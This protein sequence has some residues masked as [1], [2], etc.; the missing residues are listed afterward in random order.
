MKKKVLKAP[1]A[2]GQLTRVNLVREAKTFLQK[3]VD[4]GYDEDEILVTI[5]QMIS[6]LTK[7]AP[8]QITESELPEF[9]REFVERLLGSGISEN[10]IMDALNQVAILLIRSRRKAHEH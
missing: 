8:Q 2:D 3:L 5:K 7:D 10:K 4:A 9:T 6:W 1:S